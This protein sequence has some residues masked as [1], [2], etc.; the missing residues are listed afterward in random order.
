MNITNLLGTTLAL[1]ATVG[2][3]ALSA[4]AVQLEDGTVY[5]TQPP[6]LIRATTTFKGVDMWGAT[7][8][9]TLDVPSTAGEP[10]QKVTIAQKQGMEDIN[11]EL[12]ETQAF[13]GRGDSGPKLTLGEVTRERKTGVVS[14]TFNPPVPP[15]KTVTLGLH[16]E[17]NPRFEGVYLFGVTAFPSGEKAHGQF[18]GFG[19]LTFY[20]N[21]FR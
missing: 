17:R 5:F 12:K 15:G 10:L 16:P 6:F 2:G 1:T 18:L 14:V 7:Y 3:L 21:D 13:E 9:F 4:Q 19:R 20:S 11:Y 8:Y